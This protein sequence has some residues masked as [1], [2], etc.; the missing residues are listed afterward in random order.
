[1]R[2]PLLSL[3]LLISLFIQ[4]QQIQISGTVFSKSGQPLRG[5]TVRLLDTDS[6]QRAISL[7]DSIGHFILKDIKIK[8]GILSV[9]H[10]GFFENNKSFFSDSLNSNF[11]FIMEEK[12]IALDEVIIGANKKSDGRWIFILSPEQRRRSYT[13]YDVISN[14]MLPGVSVDKRTQSIT[15]LGTEL[16]VYI[17]G[18]RASTRELL[19]LRKHEIEQVD[20]YDFP[21]G[22]FAGDMAAVNIIIKKTSGG[23]TSFDGEESIGKTIGRYNIVSKY[24]KDHYTWALWTGLSHQSIIDEEKLTEIYATNPDILQRL[25]ENTIKNN[26]EH[27]YVQSSLSYTKKDNI[28]MIRPGLNYTVPHSYNL[29]LL[30]E[31]SVT[32][33]QT[34]INSKSKIISPSI[35]S[36]GYFRLSPK[37]SIEV[38]IDGLYSNNHLNRSFLEGNEIGKVTAVEKLFRLN[39]T[40]SYIQTFNNSSTFSVRLHQYYKN[41][42]TKYQ[43]EDSPVSQRLH[44]YECIL[45]AGYNQSITKNI[46]Y[47]IQL[48]GS[49]MT[50][51]LNEYKEIVKIN[52]RFNMALL[53]QKREQYSAQ[54]GLNIGNSFPNI[55][56]LNETSYKLNAITYTK[57][58]PQLKVSTLISPFSAYTIKRGKV[59]LNAKLNYLYIIDP[60][61]SD[62]KLRDNYFIKSYENNGYWHDFKSE[63][64]VSWKVFPTMEVRATINN[65]YTAHH[66]SH[67]SIFTLLGKNEINFTLGDMYFETSLTTPYKALSFALEQ[68][69]MPWTYFLTIG[70]VHGAFQ[71]EINAYNLLFH[72]QDIVRNIDVPVYQQLQTTTSL[73]THQYASLRLSYTFNYGK[74]TNKAP[75]YTRQATESAIL[76]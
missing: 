54:I 6:T 13:G 42:H 7:V 59:M 55:N 67:T 62:Y 73:Q 60:V 17:D 12:S 64:G 65:Y 29:G 32:D 61:I 39:A 28:M 10:I 45:F 46:M 14:L 57:G 16:P 63:I 1:M 51:R 52:P 76:Q 9:C 71:T 69:K 2:I 21:T 26:E 4:A 19:A 34:A 11:S 50:Y 31:N 43:I 70:Y 23:H 35:F 47:R 68:K 36:Y 5:A 40:T 24:G 53:S 25:Q 22:R 18:H 58:N 37:Q 33:L 44:S 41:S 72:K 56:T 48:G 27:Y 38:S 66:P 30:K 49:L 15:M 74:K 3:T 8:E 20:F 75:N